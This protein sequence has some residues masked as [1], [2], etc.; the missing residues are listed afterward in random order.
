MRGIVH[1]RSGS[2][3]TLFVEPEE[4]V[5]LNNQITQRSLEERDEELRLLTELTAQVHARLPE[6]SLLVDGLGAL[7][8]AFA[9]AA[10][11]ERLDASAPAVADGG[12]LELRAARHPLL[13][14][15][16]EARG[17]PVVPVD[18]LLPADRPALS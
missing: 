11:A 7:D 12:D 1:D 3:A 10:L 15:Q 9:R 18:L 13:V 8:L 4:V 2:G 16:R 14:A 5:E 17:G 6:L